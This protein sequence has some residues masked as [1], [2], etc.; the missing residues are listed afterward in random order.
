MIELSCTAFLKQYA[1]VLAIDYFLA[2]Q[3]SLALGRDQD[4]LLFFSVIGLNSSLRE[5]HSCLPIDEWAGR[6][7][8][9]RLD[10]QLNP[11]PGTGYLFPDADQWRQ[12]LSSL[13]ITPEQ[14]QPLV[15]DM[16]RLYLRRYWQFE[17]SLAATLVERQSAHSTLTFDPAD[18]YRILD[19]LFP[20]TTTPNEQEIDWQKMAVVNA[21]CHSFSV[22]AGGPGTGKTTTVTKLLAALIMLHSQHH[23]DPLVI[24]LTAPTGKAAQ[25]LTES[26]RSAKQQLSKQGI[27]AKTI[28]LIPEDAC[29]LHRLLGVIPDSYQFRYNA[30][31]LLQVDLV[32][33]DEV[34]MVDLPMMTNLFRALPSDCRVLML[35]DP[36]QLPS[37]AAGSIMADLVPSESGYSKAH[38]SLVKH[39]T[40]VSLPIAQPDTDYLTRLIKSYRFKHDGGI[41]QL[42]KQVI[43]G[44]GKASWMQLSQGHEELTL[45][46]QIDFK[47]GI[48]ALVDKYYSAQFAAP[49]IADAFAL[50]SQFRIL[51]PM[52]I[53]EQGV[54]AINVLVEKYLRGRGFILTSRELYLGKPILVTSNQYDLGLFNGDIGLV[55]E[56]EGVLKVA[57]PTAPDEHGQPQFRWVLPTRLAKFETV[58][59]MTIHKTQGSEF[60]TVAMVVPE[61]VGRMLTRELLYTGI[62]RAK[63]KLHIIASQASW[64]QGVKAKVSRASGLAERLG[65]SE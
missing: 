31:R 2:K 49:D 65:Y 15:F 25:R 24:R 14:T 6:C 26:I 50:F 55:W 22:I 11:E 30:N 1:D 5:G 23:T 27:D 51:T 47:S 35:G 9:Q 53:G 17:T 45:V 48:L 13:G 34:S 29:T 32:L 19:T 39:L 42:A 18:L 61:Q 12:H 40:D 60:A 59:A 16:D 56:H 44:N 8:W 57:F 7:Q 28:D 41:G 46:P 58:Y 38:A 63:S 20:N 64:A 10:E 52:R 54:E 37:V 21:L 62:T 4:A 43:T 33:V 3:I 36:D